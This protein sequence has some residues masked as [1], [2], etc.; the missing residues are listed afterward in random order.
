[1]AA[2]YDVFISSLIGF[3]LNKYPGILDNSDKYFTLSE[4][5]KLGSIEEA[6]QRILEREIDEVM[7]DSHLNQIEWFD[8]KLKKNIKSMLRDIPS[9][10]EIFERRNLY[11]HS[12]D[13]VSVRYI[14]NC[15]K[16]GSLDKDLPSV[17]VSL[18]S[19]GRYIFNA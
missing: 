13:L 16:Y 17:G 7:F 18:I 3:Y 11:A 14:N 15:K 9:F 10:C 1:M 12:S 8:K 4:L 19:G 6:Q 5:K 2:Q